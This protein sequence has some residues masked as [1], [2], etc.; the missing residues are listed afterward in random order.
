MVSLSGLDLIALKELAPRT[1][2]GLVMLLM[3]TIFIPGLSA[4]TREPATAVVVLAVAF[5]VMMVLLANV[6]CVPITVTTVELAGLRNI[7][8]PKLAELTLPLGMP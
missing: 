5:L 4:P 1:S 7:W 8:L 6:L 3:Q 2:L